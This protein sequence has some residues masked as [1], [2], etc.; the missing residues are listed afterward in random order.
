MKFTVGAPVGGPG[1]FVRGAEP[2]EAFVAQLLAI[3]G[4]T[5]VFLT[6]DFVTISKTPAGSWDEMVPVATEILE[7]HFSG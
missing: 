5:S 3:E 6:A 2:E 4:V 7:S 1:T